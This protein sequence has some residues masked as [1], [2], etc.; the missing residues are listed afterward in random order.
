M[1]MMEQIVNNGILI[2]HCDGGLQ[3]FGHQEHI[4]NSTVTGSAIN[5]RFVL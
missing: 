1:Q 3:M 2:A 5:V 4:N